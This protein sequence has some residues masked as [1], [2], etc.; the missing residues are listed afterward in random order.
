VQQDVL[1]ARQF[2]GLNA[3]FAA[4]AERH[5]KVHEEFGNT[6]AELQWWSEK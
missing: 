4:A 3:A 1:L 2:D 6:V 5:D